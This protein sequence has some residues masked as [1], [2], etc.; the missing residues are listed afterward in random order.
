MDTVFLDDITGTIGEW[1]DNGFDEEVPQSAI[2]ML[3]NAYKI[4][5]DEYGKKDENTTVKLSSLAGR[6]KLSGVELGVIHN[7]ATKE[8]QNYVKFTLDNVHYLAVED[9]S[10][11][12]RSYCKELVVTEKPPRFSFEPQDM[13]CMMMESF[14]GGFENDIL[15]MK[16]ADNGKVVL[17]IGTANVDDWYPCCRFHYKP[18]NMSCNNF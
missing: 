10:D 7:I 4:C 12:Y 16:D 2:D 1:M 18:E 15:V 17:E 14:P 9:P 6:H 5:R 13:D 11:G 3:T 8:E